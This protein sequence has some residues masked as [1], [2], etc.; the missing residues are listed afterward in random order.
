VR[1]PA[2]PHPDFVLT[3]DDVTNGREFMFRACGG[4]F[5]R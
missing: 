2:M 3:S 1:S 5:F 4:R